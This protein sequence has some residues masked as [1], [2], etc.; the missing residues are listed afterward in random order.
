MTEELNQQAGAPPAH[1]VN[2]PT[3][4]MTAAEVQAMM[5]PFLQQMQDMQKQQ[6]DLLRQLALQKAEIDKARLG[7]GTAV[8]EALASQPAWS[9][10]D[11]VASLE[12]TVAALVNGLAHYVHE[13]NQGNGR[14]AL[15]R[16]EDRLRELLPRE[17]GADPLPVLSSSQPKPV[18]APSPQP[19]LS[20]A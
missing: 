12:E 19:A 8:R 11:V 18:A 9:H 6:A 15:Q 10:A 17:D 3:Q 1:V 4:V 7:V 5:A 14:L 20:G 16:L 13:H 2:P